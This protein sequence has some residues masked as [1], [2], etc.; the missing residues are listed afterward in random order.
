MR[1]TSPRMSKASSASGSVFSGTIRHNDLE[2]GF[3]ELVGDDGDVWRLEGK[4]DATVGARV[5]VHGRLES[6]GFGIHMSG[7]SIA[8]SKIEPA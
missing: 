6:G 8:V 2:G 5:R 3:Y 7:P 4:F 1:Y